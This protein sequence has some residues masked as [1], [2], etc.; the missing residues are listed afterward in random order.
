MSNIKSPKEVEAYE[1]VKKQ[2]EDEYKA[3]KSHKLRDFLLRP[4]K[5]IK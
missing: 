4:F 5:A 3:K 2:I 1:E